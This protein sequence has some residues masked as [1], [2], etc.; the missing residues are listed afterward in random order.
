[1]HELAMAQDLWRIILKA[2][3]SNSLKKIT[4]VKIQ[5]GSNSGV[6]KE[7]LEHSLKEHIFPST[8]ADSANLDFIEENPELKCRDCGKVYAGEIGSLKCESCGSYNLDASAGAGVSI[9]EVQGE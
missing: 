4:D 6:Q 2:A 7:F 9:L 3:D 5:I 8:I 1:M